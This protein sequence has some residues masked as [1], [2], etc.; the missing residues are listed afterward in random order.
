MSALSERLRPASFRGVPFLVEEASADSTRR[1]VVHEFP[2]SD[3]PSIEDLGAGARSFTLDGFVTGPDFLA[4]RDRLLTA[5][6]EE[7]PG[8]LVHPLR[9][10]LSVWVLRHCT[11]ESTRPLGRVDFSISFLL[12]ESEEERAAALPATPPDTRAGALE[13]SLGVR[14]SF[15][16]VFRVDG[17]DLEALNEARA[18]VSQVLDAYDTAIQSLGESIGKVQEAAFLVRS[19]RSRVSD[20]LALPGALAEQLGAVA[21]VVRR[22]LEGRPTALAES[23]RATP[24][25]SPGRA[26]LRNIASSA[27]G[28][29]RV[30]F[31]SAFL[32]AATIL[33]PVAAP[34]SARAENARALS[35]VVLA[36]TAA[37][38]LAALEEPFLTTSDAAVARG[39]TLDVL[40]SLQAGT[41]DDALW[42]T[43]ADLRASVFA[44]A[45]ATLRDERVIQ[46]DPDTP[47]LVVAWETAGSALLA[48]ELCVRNGARDPLS[49]PREMRVL[50]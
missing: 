37:S 11:R 44:R 8:E 13:M 40:E 27:L 31:W 48:D 25:S 39:V 50:I 43:L 34:G 49:L 10:A 22:A 29:I 15:A 24:T 35:R 2:E 5:L 1:L 6:D 20:L 28:P 21:D 17:L 16:S 18:S 46:V 41:D 12:A 45:A 14:K 19:V 9:G 23:E 3:V 42:L 47:A 4:A 26:L 32:E 7:G 38:L 36:D 33:S 30:S